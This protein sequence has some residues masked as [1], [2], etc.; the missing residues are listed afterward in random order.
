VTT[1]LRREVLYNYI[2]RRNIS[3]NGFA[4][5]AGISSGYI[6]QLLSGKRTPSGRVR[7]K[8]LHATGL[9]FDELF[10]IE[11]LKIPSL[12]EVIKP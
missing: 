2:E 12:H 5:K 7:Q 10:T 6:A 9:S 4:L 11:P 3:Q 1:K 8:L